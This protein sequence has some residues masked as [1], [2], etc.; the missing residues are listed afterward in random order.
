MFLFYLYF[1]SL[2]LKYLKLTKMGVNLFCDETLIMKS[3][4]TKLINIISTIMESKIETNLFLYLKHYIS[5]HKIMIKRITY[6]I[7]FFIF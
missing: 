1:S 3:S 5:R 4:N 6:F 2:I 7:I